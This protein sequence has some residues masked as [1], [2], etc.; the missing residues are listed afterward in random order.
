MLVDLIG[1]QGITITSNYQKWRNE[2]KEGKLPSNCFHSIC[3]DTTLMECGESALFDLSL[4]VD[5]IIQ[6]TF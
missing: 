6:E 5:E 1:S 4:C 3:F 2:E